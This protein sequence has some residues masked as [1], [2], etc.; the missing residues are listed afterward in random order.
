MQCQQEAGGA[1]EDIIELEDVK[2][3]ATAKIVSSGATYEVLQRV[4]C[5]SGPDSVGIGTALL[6]GMS[7]PLEQ[8][9]HT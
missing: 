9:C 3:G 8:E 2:L 7:K 1:W 5:T 6:P 4:S